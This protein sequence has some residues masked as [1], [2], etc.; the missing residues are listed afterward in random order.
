MI[1]TSVTITMSLCR[2]SLFFLYFCFDIT[3]HQV[4]TQL[5]DKNYL[6]ALRSVI[7]KLNFNQ[8]SYDEFRND[9]KQLATVDPD[10]LNDCYDSSF[11]ERNLNIIHMDLNT[12]I[13]EYFNTPEQIQLLS[14]ELSDGNQ[15]TDQL[16]EQRVEIL[17]TNIL[18]LTKEVLKC[19]ESPKEKRSRLGITSISHLSEE[20]FQSLLGDQLYDSM[21][22]SSSEIISGPNLQ[23]PMKYSWTDH[24]AVTPIRNQFRCGSCAVFSAVATVE[25]AYLIH[26]G[27]KRMISPQ[28]IDLSEQSVLDCLQ[29]GV[30]K[31]GS[32][33][34]E[35]WNIIKRKG[36]STERER[37]YQA[38]QTGHCNRNP[39]SLIYMK[40]WIQN[41][42]NTEKYM[43]RLILQYGPISALIDARKLHHLKGP[44]HGYCGQ[45]ITHAVVIVGWIQKYWI[46]KNSW[47]KNWGLNGFL[48]LPRG[49][50]KCN[51]QYYAGVPFIR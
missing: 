43:Q 35:S 28:S 33:V 16:L 40:K 13:E 4:R 3:I 19:L 14:M 32:Y 45:K 17:A 23:I 34:D 46:I 24:N 11:G 12:I 50:N 26:Y 21:Q 8:L 22:N 36:I 25:S 10:D 51:I 5:D 42:Q 18:Q 20:E 44:F 49:Q 1:E 39:Q 48:Y 15:H 27:R 9:I 31:D 38:R 30:C 41:Y 47:G 6:L 7:K 2:S 29:N 37:P